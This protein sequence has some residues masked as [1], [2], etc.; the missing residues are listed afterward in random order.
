VATLIE[1]AIDIG[2]RSAR[3]SQ[4]AK[5]YLATPVINEPSPVSQMAVNYVE[6]YSVAYA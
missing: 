2:A 3:A 1:V 5:D 6:P 4:A